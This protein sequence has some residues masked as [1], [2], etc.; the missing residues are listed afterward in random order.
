MTV[1][2]ARDAQ[3]LLGNEAIALAACHAGVRV[4]TGYPG[5]PS[6]E[7]LEYLARIA[8]A[9]VCVEWSTNEK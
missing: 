9:D 1:D 6:T 5:T 3:L 4:A 8:Q 7:T 2:A